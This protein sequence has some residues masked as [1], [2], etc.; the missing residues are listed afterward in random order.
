MNPDN[1]A[2]QIRTFRIGPKNRRIEDASSSAQPNGYQVIVE[3]NLSL[4]ELLD[5]HG[6]T[7]APSESQITP[8]NFP[9]ASEA[10]TSRF[11]ELFDFSARSEYGR[12]GVDEAFVRDKLEHFKFRPATLPELI[13]FASHLRETYHGQWFEGRNILALGSVL[14]TTEMHQKAGWFRKAAIA[15]YRHYPEL[16]CVSGRPHDVLSLSRTERDSDGNWPS[17]TLFLAATLH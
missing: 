9:H 13:C 7:V 8:E 1:S 11:F 10:S 15:H 5:R 17:A 2:M 16:E 12:R 4:P 3:A 6:V 14:V